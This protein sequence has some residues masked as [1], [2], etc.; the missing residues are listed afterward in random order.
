MF[1]GVRNVVAGVRTS[2]RYG[3]RANAEQ[4]AHGMDA[5]TVV[6]ITAVLSV[7]VFFFLVENGV[8]RDIPSFG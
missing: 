5:F 3:A 6:Y 1:A 8:D 2:R 4:S 7:I